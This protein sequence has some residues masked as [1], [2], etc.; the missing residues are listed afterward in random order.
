MAMWPQFCAIAHRRLCGHLPPAWLLFDGS[1]RA[2]GRDRLRRDP[3]ATRP[4][5]LGA[6]DQ[7]LEAARHPPRAY[8]GSRRLLAPRGLRVPCLGLEQRI[9]RIL[10]RLTNRLTRRANSASH[11]LRQ[12]HETPANCHLGDPQ[13]APHNPKVAGSNPAPAIPGDKAQDPQALLTARPKPQGPPQ[14]GLCRCR[15]G[16]RACSHR[17]FNLRAFVA[18]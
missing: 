17:I 16:G 1:S 5:A 13:E 8:R 11:S 6:R 12:D 15:S 18:S 9:E 10:K 14:G 4:V 3:A 2:R 7:S